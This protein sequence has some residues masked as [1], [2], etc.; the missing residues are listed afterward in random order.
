[1]SL[2]V[3]HVPQTGG[4]NTP[5]QEV[6]PVGTYMARTVQVVD[7]GMQP[8]SYLGQER[9]PA[10]EIFLGYELVSCFCKDENG[11]IDKSKPRWVSERFPLR[12]IKAE[13]ATST[14]RLNT[15]DPEG[16]CK[17]DFSLILG[18]PCLVTIVHNKSKKTGEPYAAISMVAPPMAGMDCPPLVNEPRLFLLDNPNL[19]DFNA[20]P[21]FM[22]DIILNNLE[23]NG[24]PLS[25]LISGN[26]P[27]EEEQNA[28]DMMDECP[29]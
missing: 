6:I 21:M 9:S 28:T 5:K 27:A 16:K 15:L 2:N 8:Q 22:K 7:L 12:H 3:N 10:R 1:M 24:S 26:A 19:D 4:K 23:F 29:F 13:K 18:L 17:G 25:R 20:L 14:K 11:E